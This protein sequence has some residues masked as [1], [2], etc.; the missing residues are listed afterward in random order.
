MKSRTN[1]RNPLKKALPPAPKVVPKKS[2]TAK[3]ISKGSTNA[4]AKSKK[5][6]DTESESEVDDSMSFSMTKLTQKEQKSKKEKEKKST[7]S[8]KEKPKSSGQKPGAPG[9]KASSSAKAASMLSGSGSEDTDTSLIRDLSGSRPKSK[10]SPSPPTLLPQKSKV[11]G[12]K[13]SHQ[14]PMKVPPSSKKPPAKKP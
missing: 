7:K 14:P 6:I 3:T 9:S 5:Y 13:T 2:A 10:K 12:S 8:P 11:K 4:P 1:P